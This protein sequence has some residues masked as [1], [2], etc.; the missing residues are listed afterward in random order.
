MQQLL[1]QEQ[2]RHQQQQQQHK[3]GQDQ[4]L[5]LV[6]QQECRTLFW[7]DPSRNLQLKINYI[8]LIKN[9]LYLS[10]G[11]HKVVQSTREALV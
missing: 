5:Q 11:F 4:M 9:T 8:F 10:L 1:G 6:N 7:P 2:L 3:L